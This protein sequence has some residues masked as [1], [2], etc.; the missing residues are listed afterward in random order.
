MSSVTNIMILGSFSDDELAFVGE[1]MK[2]LY[3]NQ[4]YK[5]KG[6]IQFTDKF[7]WVMHGSVLIGTFNYLDE[8]ILFNI[9]QT[10][11]HFDDW[12]HLQLGI[13]DESDD[14]WRFYKLCEIK[15]VT[16]E[17]LTARIQ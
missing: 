5:E 13:M 11:K 3:Q 17:D 15:C 16:G 7:T 6:L 9:T 14:F 10:W 8:D 12:T 2:P 1:S 4:H